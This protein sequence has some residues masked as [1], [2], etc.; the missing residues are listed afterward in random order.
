MDYVKERADENAKLF[1]AVPSFEEEKLEIA[2]I[3][4]AEEVE[5]KVSF[6]RR[7]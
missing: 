2:E 5:N 7:R 4:L 1:G 3:E 6:S